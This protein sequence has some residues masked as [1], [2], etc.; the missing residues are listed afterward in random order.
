MNPFKILE[1]DEKATKREIIVA[2]A[3]ALRDRKYSAKEIAQAQKTLLNPQKKFDELISNID[4]TIMYE[5]IDIRKPEK[6]ST[7]CLNNPIL[8]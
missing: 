4:F 2:A 5:N 7:E 1:I 8:I 3:K 6:I